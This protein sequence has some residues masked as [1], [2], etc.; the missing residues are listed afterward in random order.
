VHPALPTL[1][2]S[3][4]SPDLTPLTT[5]LTPPPLSLLLQIG[6]YGILLYGYPDGL[7]LVFCNVVGLFTW[8]VQ[9]AVMLYFTK[10]AASKLAF[11]AQYL[12]CLL[13]G[14]CLPIGVFLGTDLPL[15][16][17]QL[18]VAVF[19]Q[20]ANVA[21]FLSPVAALREAL[22]DRDL[23]RTPGALS[24]VNLLNSSL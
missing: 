5:P 24:L 8:M 10:G 13:W 15:P 17:K 12:A 22:R 23:R 20:T 21:G 14:V 9:F 16:S 2:R 7:Q 18:I 19:M 3:L 1:T 6:L 11:F 4:A